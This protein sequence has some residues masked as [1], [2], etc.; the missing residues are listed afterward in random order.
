MSL[1]ELF[2]LFLIL[3]VVAFPILYVAWLLGILLWPLAKSVGTVLGFMAAVAVMI[4]LTV[5]AP[6]L[7]GL[8]LLFALIVGAVGALLDRSGTE[9]MQ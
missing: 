4:W 5:H 6:I 9:E 2:G 3:I 1:L 8:A 7:M